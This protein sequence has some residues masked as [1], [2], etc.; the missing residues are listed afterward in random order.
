MSWTYTPG[1]PIF[2]VRSLI[3]D[4]DPVKVIFTD[5]ELN[6]YLF[7]N[8]SQGLYSSGQAWPIGT[9]QTMPVQVYSYY[10]A[11][12]QAID[13]I[14]SNRARLATV[15]MILDVK[16]NPGIAAKTLHDIA[17]GLREQDE[18]MSFGIV[19]QVFDP[20]SARERAINQLLRLEAGS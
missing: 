7:L 5:E 20:F 4:T 6:G 10:R 11:A 13:V 8:S 14:A 15:E 17:E 12:A 16:L 19:E 1:T 18:N 9:T 3:P 2:Y